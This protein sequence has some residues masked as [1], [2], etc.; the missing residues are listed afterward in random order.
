MGLEWTETVSDIPCFAV[1]VLTR[2]G[3][4]QINRKGS[5]A[6]VGQNRKDFGPGVLTRRFLLPLGSEKFHG[7]GK[8]NG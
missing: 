7:I 4:D 5:R 8:L 6:C 1:S 2:A 3:A